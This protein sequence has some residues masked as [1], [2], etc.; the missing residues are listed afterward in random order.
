ML[1]QTTAAAVAPRFEAF[2]EAF[3]T[4]EAL[5]AAPVEIVMQHWAG[6]GYYARARNLHATA[7][8]VAERGGRLPDTAE[9]LRALPGVGAYTAAAIAAIAFDEPATVVDGNV[10]R[11]VARLFAHAAPLPG[12]KPALRALAER[13]TPQVRPGDFAQAM[14]DLGATVC[15]PRKPQ[16]PVCPVRAWCQAAASGDADRLPTK[17]RKAAKPVRFGAA[18]F[19]RRGD[20]VWLVRRAPKGLLGGM[21]ALP[22]TT[23][24][25]DAPAG[26]HATAPS[27]GAWR[28]A[29]EAHHVFTHF[30]LRLAVYVARTRT[31]PSGEG[32]WAP[33]AE[34]EGAGLP[35]VFLK[36]ARIGAL[37]A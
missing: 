18:Y 35:T 36:A 24:A 23:W 17:T 7:R 10:E 21:A 34:L 30:E 19:L 28:Q 32:W 29:G 26:I 16:C 4:L 14:M 12:A 1:Q 31:R 20:A 3:P 25:A 2:L 33:I 15:T 22:S 8:L 11:V 5:A 37:K 6:L 13:L 27:E 9:A